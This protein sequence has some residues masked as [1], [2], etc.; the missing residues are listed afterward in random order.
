ME[1]IK[2]QKIQIKKIIHNKYTIAQ[3]LA[4]INEA[5]KNSLHSVSAKYGIDRKSIRL[6]ISQKQELINQEN[7][8]NTE[9]IITQDIN[10][11]LIILKK[12]F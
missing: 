12:I 6:W 9:L 11:L 7:K 5:E 2:S 4:I 3:K 10:L 8:K 1:N